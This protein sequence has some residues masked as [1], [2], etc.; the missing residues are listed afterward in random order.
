MIQSLLELQKRFKF[1][2]QK[3]EEQEKTISRPQLQKI[4]ELGCDLE[5]NPVLE[6]YFTTRQH[7]ILKL[8]LNDIGRILT[9]PVASSDSNK[10]SSKVYVVCLA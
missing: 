2:Q 1:D 3:T 9:M 7:A 10:K 8:N 5:D 6:K 4:T